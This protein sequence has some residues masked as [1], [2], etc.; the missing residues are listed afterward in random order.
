MIDE[1]T[2]NIILEAATFSLYNLR[3]TQM[4]H[5]I[6]SEAITRFTKGQPPY[7]TLVVAE[8]CARM[9]A[10]G[11]VVTA[12]ADEYPKPKKRVV[13]KITTDEI[14]NLLGTN[15][16]KDLIANTLANVGFLIDLSF[17]DGSFAPVVTGQAPSSSDVTSG[18]PSRK[19][20]RKTQLNIESPLWRTDIHIKEDIIEEVGRLLGYD[21]IEPTLPLHGTAEKNE[22]WDV[23]AR[24]RDILARFGANEV[25][26]Y[27][28]VSER[29][30]EKV[31]QEQNNSYRIVN[32][33]S[34][35][36]Q[37]VRQS[38]VPSLLSKAYLNE[39]LPV[40]KF[41]LFEINKVYQKAW[42]VD[43]EKVP[44]EKMQLGF[45]VAERKNTETAFYKAKW[46]AAK[47]L[48]EL[49]ISMNFLPFKSEKVT[50]GAIDAISRPFELK[51]SAKICVG[52]QMIGVVGEFKN[53]VKHEFK[54][55]D[56]AAGFEINLDALLNQVPRLHQVKFATKKKEDVTVTTNKTYAEV[57]AELQDKY[58]EA[59]ITPGTVYQAP[60]QRSKNITFHISS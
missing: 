3:K 23:K 30:L 45:V 20:I 46:Y 38:I 44:V 41:A 26:T 58:P 10:D 14:N 4:A 29:L 34:Q 48:E 56:Y 32:S 5:G 50:D 7:Q 43:E 47:L 21:N 59:T 11:F 24:V 18:S 6:F 15:Y 28:F 9:L 54:L 52:E 53:S 49:N 13:V 12:M 17:G 2:K 8:S 31:G 39:K 22:M 33:I 36:L 37:L 40:E 19:A 51:R 27:S 35:E 57:L 25:L 1:N 42:G 16:D 60:G 55:A